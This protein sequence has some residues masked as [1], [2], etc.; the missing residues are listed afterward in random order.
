M[1]I[2]RIKGTKPCKPHQQAKSLST[3]DLTRQRGPW[4][5][6]QLLRP[7]ILLTSPIVQDGNSS[8]PIFSLPCAKFS[9]Q[10]TVL[11]SATFHDTSL[12]ITAQSG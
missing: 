1:E 4:L 10:K 12:S 5:R 2:N 9:S 6:G 7:L 11:W 3:L 8:S